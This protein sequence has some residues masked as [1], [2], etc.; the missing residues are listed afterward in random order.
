[1]KKT[2]LLSLQVGMPKLLGKPGTTDPSER[3]WSTGIFKEPVIGPIWLGRTNLTGDGQADLT[4]H[5][6]PDKTVLAYSAEHYPAWRAELKRNDFTFGAFGENFTITG[7]NEDEVCVGDI[8]EIGESRV[9]VSQPRR[10]CWKLARKWSLPQLPARV[11]A[12]GRS[13]WYLR[14]MQEGHVAVNQPVRLVAREFPQWS[15][16]RVSGIINNIEE[17]REEAARLAQ[18]EALAEDLRHRLA[19]RIGLFTDFV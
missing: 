12:T 13:G 3:L 2:I 14:V 19:E 9:Q 7:L 8:Y 11:V 15:I 16:H 4:V 17:N 1:M 18:C 6:G 10:P 5:G